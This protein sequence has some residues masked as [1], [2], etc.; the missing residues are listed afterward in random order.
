VPSFV[1]VQA[2]SVNKN[3]TFRSTSNAADPLGLRLPQFGGDLMPHRFC[4]D[5]GSATG[6]HTLRGEACDSLVK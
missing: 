6:E 3:V 4:A 2:G 1:C 5:D